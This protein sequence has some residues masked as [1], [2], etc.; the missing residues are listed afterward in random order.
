V[1]RGPRLLGELNPDERLLVGAMSRARF[2]RIEG[3]RVL[4]GRRVLT[5]AP[6]IVERI[7]LTKTTEQITVGDDFE[8]KPQVRKLVAALRRLKNDTVSSLQFANGLPT[9]M[10]VKRDLTS[11]E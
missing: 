1:E 11:E 10:E 4:D 9:S 2:G 8:L 7:E 3:L 6:V 5:P